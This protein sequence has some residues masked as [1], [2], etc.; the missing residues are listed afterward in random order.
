MLSRTL[1]HIH[2]PTPIRG[3][4]QEREL[5]RTLFRRGGHVR[6]DGM[7]RISRELRGY[8][9]I[10]GRRLDVPYAVMTALHVSACVRHALND[11]RIG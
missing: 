10:L 1:V 7:R 4:L 8:D 6:Q 9:E 11:G 2:G 3:N 5:C